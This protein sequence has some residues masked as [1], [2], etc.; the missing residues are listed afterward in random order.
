M[1][2]ALTFGFDEQTL[3]YDL[4]RAHSADIWFL[5]A[6]F[7]FWGTIAG[8]SGFFIGHALPL[9]GVNFY[10]SAWEGFWDFIHH[11]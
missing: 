8:L 2:D 3:A 1:L 9:M 4:Q 10:A 7:Y 5:R 6:R 11:F